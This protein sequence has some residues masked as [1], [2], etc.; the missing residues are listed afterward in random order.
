MKKAIFFLT[1]IAWIPTVRAQN[2]GFNWIQQAGSTGNV[3]CNVIAY[4]GENHCLVAGNHS[5]TVELTSAD[6]NHISLIPAGNDVFIAKYDLDGN[7]VWAIGGSD[8]V[9]YDIAVD[10]QGNCYITGYFRGT[11][12]FGPGDPN[13]TNLVCAGGEDI[14][15]AKYTSSGNLIW[16]KRAGSPEYDYC[17]GIAVDDNGYC[18]ISG[19]FEGTAT[20]GAGESN[21]TALTSGGDDDFFIARYDTD[22]DLCWAK[23]AGGSQLVVGLDIAA[24]GT[25]A[26]SV[27]GRLHGTA[28]FGTGEANETVLN[29]QGESDIFVALFDSSGFLQWV[30]IAGGAERDFGAAVAM[31][32]AGNIFVTGRFEDEAVFELDKPQE[33]RINSSGEFDLFVAK[34]DILGNL[35]WVTSDGGPKWDLGYSIAMN[36]KDHCLVAGKF[37]S[38]VVFGAGQVGETSLTTEGWADVFFAEYTDDGELVWAVSAGGE[39]NDYGDAISAGPSGSVL[40]AGKFQEEVSFDSIILNSLGS[41]D[42]FIAYWI[43]DTTDVEEEKEMTLISPNGGESWPVGSVRIIKWQSSNV[44]GYVTIELSRNGAA[45][46]EIGSVDVNSGA[47]A[48]DVTGSVSGNCLIKITG[49]GQVVSDSS[50]SYFSIIEQSGNI[51]EIAYIHADIAIMDAANGYK[52]ML[53]TS[54]CPTTIINNSEITQTDFSDYDLILL[55][56]FWVSQWI[57]A[58][59]AIDTLNNSGKPIIGLGRGGYRFFGYLNLDIGHPHGAQFNDMNAYVL[60]PWMSLY[61]E[62][63]IIHV[64]ADS[65]LQF[66]SSSS[67][68]AIAAS[69]DP[70]LTLIAGVVDHNN[71]YGIVKEEDRYLLWGFGAVP[72]SLTQIGRD[73]FVNLITYMV[74]WVPQTT[75]VD[76]DYGPVEVNT[77][78]LIQNYPNPFNPVTNINFNIP[79]QSHVTFSVY[80]L[81]GREITQLLNEKRDAGNYA[82]LFDGSNLPS[83]IYMYKLRAGQYQQVRKMILLK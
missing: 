33:I 47:Y 80:D 51:R 11:A 7:L 40:L 79:Q 53:D 10:K 2:P 64:P 5:A 70:S 8:H 74:P 32:T 35:L 77:F 27:T 61:F 13:E 26:L 65:I 39:G 22:G 37:D 31:D 18:S 19:G 59:S 41:Y 83:G 49:E 69:T 4:D 48:W 52:A 75:G 67:N 15:L 42:G 58:Q 25:N 23:R 30:T 6:G 17:Y 72:D 56:P 38:T 78:Q 71:H 55:E 73:L 50:D 3:S 12:T 36:S 60:D 44:D 82:I 76:E 81:T 9:V 16:A 68:V 57:D 54:S 14:F 29:N 46:E 45:W 62:P 1:L 24:H 20:F 43:P 21:E 28:T 34:W 63:H 66:H